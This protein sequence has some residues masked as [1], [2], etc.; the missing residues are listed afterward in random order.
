LIK[1]GRERTPI[2][3]PVTALYSKTD[4]VVAWPAAID[5]TFRR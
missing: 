3:V 4:G 2:R 1:R 5:G